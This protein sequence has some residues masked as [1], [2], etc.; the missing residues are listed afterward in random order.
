MTSEKMSS[1]VWLLAASVLSLSSLSRVVR[2]SY[3]F[4]QLATEGVGVDR[5]IY[6]PSSAYTT[7]RYVALPPTCGIA[8]EQDMTTGRG[9]CVLMRLLFCGSLLVTRHPL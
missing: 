7:Y 6:E 3:W 4:S 1:P 8:T 2:L 9:G 5:E